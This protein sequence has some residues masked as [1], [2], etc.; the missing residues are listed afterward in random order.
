MNKIG[1]SRYCNDTED[2]KKQLSD[3]FHAKCHSV[4]FDKIDFE[5]TENIDVF[6]NGKIQFNVHFRYLINKQD[7]ENKK[8]RLFC[9]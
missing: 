2:C 7:K 9:N 8:N 1:K 5:P 3:K 4:I 6:A